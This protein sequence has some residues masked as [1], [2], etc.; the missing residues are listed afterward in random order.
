MAVTQETSAAANSFMSKLNTLMSVMDDIVQHIPEEHYLRAVNTLRDLYRDEAGRTLP[1][2]EQQ[3]RTVFMQV[4]EQ[5]IRRDP[6]MTPEQRRANRP[7]RNKKI[8]HTDAWKLKNGYKVCEKCDRIVQ[9]ITGHQLTDVCQQITNAKKL[10][11]TTGQT[12]NAD[13]TRGIALLKS[14]LVKQGVE[15]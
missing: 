13:R 6:I 3:E 4:V 11:V 15:L 9:D 1:N 10:T 8:I 14:A 5:T 2:P 12:D 7:I